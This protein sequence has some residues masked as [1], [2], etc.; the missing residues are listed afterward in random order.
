[1]HKTARVITNDPKNP[2]IPLKMSGP[3]RN[4]AVIKPNTISLRGDEGKE[5]SGR[6][7]IS[8]TKEFPFD[9][10]RT[11]ATANAKFTYALE[12]FQKEGEVSWILTVMD[13]NPS[14]RYAGTV[15]LHTDSDLRPS[16]E[17]KVYG[18][19][20]KKQPTPLSRKP[21]GPQT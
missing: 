21:V 19:F 1:M 7:N 12:K 9:I 15:Y 4:F 5:V 18:N 11:T 20:T 13:P 8:M 2:E 17:V 10:V 16:L 14:G 3:V 6:A